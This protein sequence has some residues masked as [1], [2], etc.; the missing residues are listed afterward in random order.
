MGVEEKK[1]LDMLDIAED[2]T[3]AEDMPAVGG[4]MPATFSSPGKVLE[5]SLQSARKR[6]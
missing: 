5:E 3:T 2:D 4:I 1:L 6:R